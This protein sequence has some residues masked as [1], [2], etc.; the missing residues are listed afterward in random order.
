MDSQQPNTPMR[1]VR[2]PAGSPDWI[3]EE[4]I[5][6]T[7]ETWQPHADRPLTPDDALAMLINV[8]ELFVA[9]GLIAGDER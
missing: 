6:Q 9:A 2:P 1:H 4:L 3:S 7:L 8:G 5:A